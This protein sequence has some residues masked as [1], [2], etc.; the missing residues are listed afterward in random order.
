VIVSII[1]F[2]RLT[3]ASTVRFTADVPAGEFCAEVFLD[4]AGEDTARS[5]YFP[6]VVGRGVWDAS[7]LLSALGDAPGD[8]DFFLER[9]MSAGEKEGKEVRK[10]GE[11]VG[12][13][14][15]ERSEEVVFFGRSMTGRAAR[16]EL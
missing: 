1:V 9:D 14:E 2:L 12:L 11:G 13:V 16:G 3:A 6:V 10:V 5:L 8:S 4:P 15:R 7:L